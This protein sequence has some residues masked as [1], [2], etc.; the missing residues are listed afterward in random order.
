[1]PK[2]LLFDLDNTLIDRNGAFEACLAESFHHQ[3]EPRTRLRGLDLGGWGCRDSLF[4]AWQEI[5]GQ[6]MDQSIF[7]HRLASHLRPQPET[8]NLLEELSRTYK[9][10][11]ISNGGGRGQRQKLKAAGL[12]RV[13]AAEHIWISGEVGWA[14]PDPRIFHL[15]SR[16]LGLEAVDCLYIGDS[17]A[18]DGAG[19]RAAG[20]NYRQ[21]SVGDADGLGAV[22]AAAGVR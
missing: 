22:L 11:L 4:A 2:A 18:V 1:M 7:A 17:E 9:L 19:A 13:F 5:S 15:A 12:D 10:G 3:E 20:M 21:V 6:P 14:K 8:V 16:T